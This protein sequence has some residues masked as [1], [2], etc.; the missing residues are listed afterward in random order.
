MKFLV[1]LACLLISAPLF[2]LPVIIDVGNYTIIADAEVQ[3]NATENILVQQNGQLITLTK[4]KYTQLKSLLTQIY[5][6]KPT[7]I[8]GYWLRLTSGAKPPKSQTSFHGAWVHLTN[9][10]YTVEFFAATLRPEVEEYWKQA[11]S[12]ALDP[13][14]TSK[15]PAV[16]PLQKHLLIDENGLPLN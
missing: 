13:T 12:G 15:Y 9:H 10:P 4:D 1:T 16:P 11:F 8:P 14:D 6:E 5:N 7:V 3:I 2:A